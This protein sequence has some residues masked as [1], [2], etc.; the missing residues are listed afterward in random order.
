M[1][2]DNR[3]KSH[4]YKYQIHQPTGPKLDGG[5]STVTSK[6]GKKAPKKEAKGQKWLTSQRLAGLLLSVN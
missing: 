6:K 1:S 3:L 4:Q 5:T 2:R